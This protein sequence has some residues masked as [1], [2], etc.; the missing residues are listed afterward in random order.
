M[1]SSV[2]IPQTWRVQMI[3]Q[4]SQGFK[5]E[6]T[7][8]VSDTAIVRDAA[9]ANQIA[10]AFVSW[11]TSNLRAN[12]TPTVSLVQVYM[13]DV[14]STTGTSAIYTTGLPLAGTSST[15]TAASNAA[16]II[17]WR[18]GAR[19]RSFRGRTYIVGAPLSVFSSSDGTQTNPSFVTAYN[20]AAAA[21]ITAIG[22]VPGGFTT[23]LVVASNKLAQSVEITS[24]QARTYVGTQKR[25]VKAP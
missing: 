1:G 11:W 21:L 13:L 16:P 10:A 25:R 5:A 9:R 4:Y 15:A 19:G 18:T 20:S 23:K 24:G 6:M 12:T 7:F 22:A 3:F 17:T 8:A 14:D 2:V